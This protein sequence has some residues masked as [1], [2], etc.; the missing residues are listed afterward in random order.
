MLPRSNGARWNRAERIDRRLF[1]AGLSSTLSLAP[2]L[3]A[4]RSFGAS[5][6]EPLS[7]DE[8]AWAGVSFNPCERLIERDGEVLTT[9]GGYG[10]VWY[11]RETFSD[12][13]L[14]IDWQ[15]SKLTDNSGVFFRTPG[16][17]GDDGTNCGCGSAAAL[18]A[19]RDLGHEVQIDERGFDAA[20]GTVGHAK[21]VTGA[22]YDLQAPAQS[23]ARAVGSWN[24]YVIGAVGADVWVALNGRLIN[25]YVSPAAR[26]RAGY[27]AIQSYGPASRVRFR[28]PAILKL[29]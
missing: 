15:I 29:G 16:P 2:L 21:K 3:A 19:A 24:S 11:V 8:S 10:L 14:S 1:M 27:L 7:L 5:A 23:A 17:C 22:V 4:G 18:D 25:Q 26:R 9:T 13:I 12:F 28:N 6:F 20:D